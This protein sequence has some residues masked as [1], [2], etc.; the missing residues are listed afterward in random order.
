VREGE[1]LRMRKLVLCG[2]QDEYHICQRY[3]KAEDKLVPQS[4]TVS[5]C[6]SYRDF[7]DCVLSERWIE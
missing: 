2:V 4:W 1:K 7:G 5:N 3:V 6:I